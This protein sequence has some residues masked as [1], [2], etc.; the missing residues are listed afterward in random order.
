AGVG[1]LGGAAN[2]SNKWQKRYNR[3][4]NDCMRPAPVAYGAPPAGTPAWYDYCRAK[5]RSFNSRTGLY[6]SYSGQYLPCQ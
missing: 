4:Y 5:Y 3:A 2:S 1:A 6:L